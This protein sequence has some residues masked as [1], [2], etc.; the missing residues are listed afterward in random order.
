L[1]PRA[2]WARFSRAV[3]VRDVLCRVAAGRRSFAVGRGE[4]CVR[5]GV[6]YNVERCVYD[7]R[8]ARAY[9]PTEVRR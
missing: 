8:P 9:P 1:M 4:R 5:D 6:Q 7:Q 3:W 2:E